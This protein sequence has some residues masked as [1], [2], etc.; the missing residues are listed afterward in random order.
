M[1]TMSRTAQWL[2]VTLSSVL[3]LLG[4]EDPPKQT[5]TAEQPAAPSKPR[6]AQ[7]QACQSN[8]DCG[9]GLGCSPQKVCETFQTIECRSRNEV[10][11]GEGR[12]TGSGSKCIA[13]TDAEC[14]AAT[15]CV[16]DG[17][18]TPKDGK[19]VAASSQDCADVCSKNGR[20]TI[21]DGNCIAATSKDCRD[22]AACKQADRC[23]AKLGRCISLK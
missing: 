18:C 5:T 20:C 7:G 19:C 16:N 3:V 11:K 23:I 14:K 2:G 10:C 1:R 9:D 22:S 15:V 8:Q 4:C 13:A 21:E 6:A 12:C 17:R